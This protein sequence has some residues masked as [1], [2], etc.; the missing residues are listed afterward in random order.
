[1]IHNVSCAGRS[2][3]VIKQYKGSV[4]GRC[5]ILGWGGGA[6]NFFSDI[7]IQYMYTYA[8]FF[9]CVKHNI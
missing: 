7:I 2:C 4:V 3:F 6:V 1:M 5:L 8:C 9:M